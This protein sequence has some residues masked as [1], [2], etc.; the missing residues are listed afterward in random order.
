[1]TINWWWLDQRKP[2]SP[3]DIKKAVRVAENLPDAGDHGHVQ[4][5]FPVYGK[6]LPEIP[7]GSWDLA[8]QKSVKF[9][10]LQATNAQLKRDDL[11]WHIKNPGKSR[12]AG[13][14]N[15]HPQ[16]LKTEKG[17]LV[18]VD[19]HHRLAAEQMLGLKKDMAWLLDEQDLSA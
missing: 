16:V 1:M 14:Y 15:T 4:Q 17:D 18:I 5:V 12:F 19:G 6:G 13:R 2:P 8:K 9:K 11:I 7:Q 10:E 3:Q